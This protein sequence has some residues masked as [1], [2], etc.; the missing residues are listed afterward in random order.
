MTALHRPPD[1][2]RDALC[3]GHPLGPQA[4]DTGTPAA[5]QVCVDCPV[6]HRCATDALT[7]A[8]PHTMRGGLDPAERHTIADRFGYDRPGLP[9]HGTRSRRVHR[10]HPCTC[11]DCRRAHTRWAQER[12]AQGA[13]TRRADTTPARISA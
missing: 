5:R 9:A 2:T 10:T 1:W 12:R 8:T 4:W 3:A 7:D 13:W 11:T 6:R